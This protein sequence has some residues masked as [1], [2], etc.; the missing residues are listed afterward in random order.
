MATATANRLAT[1]ERNKKVETPRRSPLP[2]VPQVIARIQP[3]EVSTRRT[4]VRLRMRT[5]PTR[6]RGMVLLLV[7]P[8]FGAVLPVLRRPGEHMDPMDLLLLTTVIILNSALLPTAPATFLLLRSITMPTPLI[9]GMDH[10]R[11]RQQRD[12]PTVTL[13]RMLLRRLLQP[14]LSPSTVPMFRRPPAT[15]VAPRT[16]PKRTPRPTTARNSLT[17]SFNQEKLLPLQRLIQS[18]PPCRLEVRE[19]SEL[20]ALSRRNAPS[21]A[22]ALRARPDLRPVAPVP[23][24]RV[25]MAATLRHIPTTITTLLTLGTGTTTPITPDSLH[26]TLIITCPRS[27]TLLLLDLRRRR[28]RTLL[29]VRRGLAQ[30]PAR[31]VTRWVCS[32]TS[33]CGTIGGVIPTQARQAVSVVRVVSLLAQPVSSVS[34][35]G[36]TF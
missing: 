30:R 3:P 34:F 24:C 15:K 4:M 7:I 14:R 1:T 22:L 36:D 9:T 13:P 12:R 10:R 35:V 16:L 23:S 18:V 8:S 28:S 26:R 6:T 2:V 31:A 5:I 33:R 20:L 27:T 25:Q 29:K 21:T 32:P 11:L 19:Q 17:R